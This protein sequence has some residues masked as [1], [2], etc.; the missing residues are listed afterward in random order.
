MSVSTPASRGG[1]AG[2][3]GGMKRDK[4]N[5]ANVGTPSLGA[6]HGVVVRSPP[7]PPFTPGS[8]PEADPSNRPNNND[9]GKKPSSN[10]LPSSRASL[11]TR[12]LCKFGYVL[13]WR[14]MCVLM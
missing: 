3:H 8:V 5:S 7:P 13:T 2:G 11:C 10:G 14:S 4:S 12:A 9:H 6:G 1:T